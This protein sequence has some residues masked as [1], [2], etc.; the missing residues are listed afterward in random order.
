[1]EKI[2]KLARYI[3]ILF[4]CIMLAS[5][6]TLRF[7]SKKGAQEQIRKSIQTNNRQKLKSALHSPERNI[8]LAKSASDFEVNGLGS[9]TN[10]TSKSTEIRLGE[11]SRA[12][13]F[14]LKEVHHN[15]KKGIV[16]RDS[17]RVL[18]GL[19][20]LSQ[21]SSPTEWRSETFELRVAVGNLLDNNL[22]KFQSGDVNE[23]T[24]QQLEEDYTR[25]IQAGTAYFIALGGKNKGTK[26]NQ[27]VMQRSQVAGGPVV[28]AIVI[29]V[30][31]ATVAFFGF[32]GAYD[33]TL[34]V[35]ISGLDSTVNSL[36]QSEDVS[37][38]SN[39]LRRIKSYGKSYNDAVRMYCNE[40]QEGWDLF[41]EVFVERDPGYWA[42]SCNVKL[43][44]D[45]CPS[46]QWFCEA[47]KYAKSCLDKRGMNW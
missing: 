35:G 31:A 20:T 6:S 22:E 24:Y 11:L 27:F 44:P 46:R 40:S 14:F 17:E 23:L 9:M 29:G 25:F 2:Q 36:C 8:T 43:F 5:C 47:I 16:Y 13:D 33:E 15:I 42:I 1:M 41:K 28:V 19:L 21:L 7:G 3:W 30:V 10:K 38:A 34:T 37:I 18:S 26:L 4:N 45:L 32:Q 39:A 12:Y